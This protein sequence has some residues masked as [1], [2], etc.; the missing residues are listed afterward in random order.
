MKS[1]FECMSIFIP[2]ESSKY[3]KKSNKQLAYIKVEHNPKYLLQLTQ[4]VLHLCSNYTLSFVID[5]QLKCLNNLY[6]LFVE[7]ATTQLKLNQF[8]LPLTRK[9]GK[10]ERQKKANSHQ[11]KENIAE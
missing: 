10:T 7:V 1:Y 6:I 11:I 9:L 8:K 3:Q 5:Q 4:Y 2:I